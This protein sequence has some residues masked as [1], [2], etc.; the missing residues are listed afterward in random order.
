MWQV[1]TCFVISENQHI[2]PEENKAS[3]FSYI[4]TGLS[5]MKE[6]TYNQEL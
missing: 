2:L 4:M 1:Y 5:W 3:S 6:V